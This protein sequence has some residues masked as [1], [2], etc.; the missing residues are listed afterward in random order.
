M[1]DAK[2]TRQTLSAWLGLGANLGRRARS[3]ARALRLLDDTEGLTL[4]EQSS[5]Y[6]T[7]PV[8]MTDQPRFLNMVARFDC[9]LTP[10][11]LLDAVHAVERR[12]RRV[13]GKRF[14]PR[15]IDVDVLL[16]GGMHIDTERLTIPHLR[17]TARQFV[18]VP[19]AEVAPDLPLPGGRTAGELAQPG[20]SNVRRLGTLDEVL[21][22]ED[23]A[24]APGDD[25]DGDV[26]D[27]G[28]D[29]AH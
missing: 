23:A 9:V 2:D 19:L 1:D 5:V 12:L 26:A 28:A 14:G 25:S 29:D 24:E 8:G 27:A 7:A 10:D 20:S 4:R 15:T 21:A 6:D 22:R 11:E 18:L 3:L 13:R 17:L 16:L